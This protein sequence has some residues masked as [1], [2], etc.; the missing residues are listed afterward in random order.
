MGFPGPLIGDGAGFLAAPCPTLPGVA[1]KLYV[2]Y[3][4]LVDQRFLVRGAK[5]GVEA[6]EKAQTFVTKQW[7]SY[8]VNK[9]LG[10]NF[11][12]LPMP[13]KDV[14]TLGPPDSY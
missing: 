2:V 3:S 9:V 11:D 4:Q 8:G 5:N 7:P 1:M 10:S 12:A 13:D 14:I 6:I